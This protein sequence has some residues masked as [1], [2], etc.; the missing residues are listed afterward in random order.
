MLQVLCILNRSNNQR[1]SVSPF[2]IEFL[3]WGVGR[4]GIEVGNGQRELSQFK[5]VL[6]QFHE[7]SAHSSLISVF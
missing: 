2:K 6:G 5:C 3:F 1:T 7:D 4:V